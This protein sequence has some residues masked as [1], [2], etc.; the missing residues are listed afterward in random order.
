[1]FHLQPIRHSVLYTHSTTLVRLWNEPVI[2]FR[3]EKVGFRHPIM[4]KSCED[5][6]NSTCA[7][8]QLVEA[9]VTEDPPA[10][11]HHA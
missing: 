5:N 3:P 10:A 6:I 9:Y 4:E 7:N 1:M 8:P 2:L 11:A